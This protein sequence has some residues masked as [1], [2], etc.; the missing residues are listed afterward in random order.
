[1][2]RIKDLLSD[3][4]NLAPYDPRLKTELLTDTS[5]LGL[6][7]VLIQFDAV[8]RKWRLIRAG[9]TALKKVQKKYPPIQLELLGLTW[10]LQSCNF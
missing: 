10:A 1:M 6:G 9:S 7:F 4:A 8:S 3:T 5:R 2:K